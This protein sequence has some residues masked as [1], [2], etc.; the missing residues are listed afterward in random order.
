M[1]LS[2]DGVEYDVKC[3]VRRT[4]DIRDSEI[5][6]ELLNGEI[7]HDVLGTYYDYVISF[8]YPLYDQNKYA[9][10][11]E[12]LTEPVDG[13]SFV[14]PYNNS[15]VTLT[16]KVDL[17]DDEQIEMESGFKY[18]RALSFG[19]TANAPT[20]A[21]TLAGVIT[22]GRAPLPDVASPTEG[23]SYTWNGNQWV[24]YEEL[25]DADNIAY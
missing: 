19:L 8:L 7:F 9:A 15:T 16:A 1:I 3:S 21:V 4:A 5:S 20:K 6:G 22:R 10:I 18:W 17:V 12:A 25:P 14:L 23:D 13:H 11:Y 24:E 2:I